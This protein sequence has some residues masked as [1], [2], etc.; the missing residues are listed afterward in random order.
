MD[1]Q[2]VG[3]IKY[4]IHETPIGHLKQTMDSLKTILGVDPLENEAIKN[5]ILKYDEDHL[6]QLTF[7][8]DKI[9]V[10]SITKDVDGYYHD[11]SKDVKIVIAPLDD[12]VE[13]MEKYSPEDSAFRVLLSDKLNAYRDKNYKVNLTAINSKHFHYKF[14]SL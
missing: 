5:E 13:S 11:Q 4:L 12:T 2:Y 10:S 1:P 7:V 9:L 6:R 14:F 3:I 8:D